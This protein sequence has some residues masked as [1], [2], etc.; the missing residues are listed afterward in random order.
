MYWR[1]KSLKSLKVEKTWKLT[2]LKNAKEKYSIRIIQP[3][4]YTQWTC[5]Q[6]EKEIMTFSGVQGFEVLFFFFL[7]SDFSLNFSQEVTGRGASSKKRIK[8]EKGKAWISET[9]IRLQDDGD[10][11]QPSRECQQ[12]G[13]GRWKDSKKGTEKMKL[14]GCQMHL[15]YMH[16]E[17]RAF[18]LGS[19]HACVIDWVCVVLV[20]KT[21]LI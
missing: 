5:I 14:T 17:E 16:R 12:H 3:E 6:Y 1:F 9:M 8:P 18:M 7:T 2:T 4:L 21:P 19:V 15:E 13:G 10:H 11:G 20:M